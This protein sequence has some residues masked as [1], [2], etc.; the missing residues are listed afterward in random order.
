MKNSISLFITVMSTFILVTVSPPGHARMKCWTNNEGVMEC[1]EKVPPEFAQKGH[2]ELSRQGMV[3]E[4]KDRAK[5]KEELAEQERL[6]AIEAEKQKKIKEQ[7]RKDKILLNTFSNIDDMQMSRDGKIAAIE[8]SIS[9]SEKR[10]EKIQ[11]DLDKRRAAAEKE[12]LSGKA[13]NEELLKDIDSLQR[14][15]NNNKTYISDKKQE[16]ENIKSAYTAD[17]DRFTKL[18]SGEIK[19]GSIE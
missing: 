12:E 10:S 6:A 4:E 2:K 11:Q 18:R 9:L 5:T 3:L 14:Q 15:L 13:P 19:V 7:A 8:S 17:I 1:G 16:I